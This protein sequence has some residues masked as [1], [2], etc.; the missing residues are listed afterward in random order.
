[1]PLLF[2][3]QNHQLPFG[4]PQPQFQQ[5]SFQP[6]DATHQNT[7]VPIAMQAE[8]YPLIPQSKPPNP[9]PTQGAVVS[10]IPS[11]FSSIKAES[12]MLS[13]SLR[14]KITVMQLRNQTLLAANL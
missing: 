6:L 10:P 13:A 3:G 1:M 12:I 4:N 11:S 9:A 5:Q 2:R 7:P 8:L 14:S